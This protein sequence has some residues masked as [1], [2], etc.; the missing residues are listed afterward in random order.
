MDAVHRFVVQLRVFV[1]RDQMTERQA[2]VRNPVN[3]DCAG[4]DF[5]SRNPLAAGFLLGLE[6]DFYHSVLAS[7]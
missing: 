5:L 7:N 3:W 1:Q 4:L 2:G 6:K